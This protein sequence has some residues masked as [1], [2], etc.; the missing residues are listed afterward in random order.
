MDNF[1]YG[2]MNIIRALYKS[3]NLFFCTNLLNLYHNNELQKFVEA[4]NMFNI[5]HKTGINLLGEIDGNMDSP[6][7]R[8]ASLGLDWYEG[9][10]CNAAIGQGAVVVTP[11]QMA[12]VASTIAN[13]GV[14][15][16]PNIID[17]ITDPFG[18]I[19]QKNDPIIEKRIPISQKTLDLINQGMHDVAYFS[20]GTVY[21]VPA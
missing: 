21:P 16:Q 11:I 1:F 9:D 10:T 2:E 13:S 19:I 12:M 20:D 7:Y 3:S 18:N 8:K 15:Y 17:K 14:Y 6:E 4:A 5:G